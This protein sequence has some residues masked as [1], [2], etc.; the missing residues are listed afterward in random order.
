MLNLFLAVDGE[1]DDTDDLASPASSTGSTPQKPSESKTGKVE[2]DLDDAPFLEIEE[3]E[4]ASASEH[5]ASTEKVTE[6]EV[7]SPAKNKKKKK[8]LAVALLAVLVLGGGAGAFFLFFGGEPEVA[9]APEEGG[10]EVVIVQRWEDNVVEAQAPTDVVRFAPFW[11]E[12]KDPEGELHILNLDFVA[13]AASTQTLSELAVKLPSL[14]DDLFFAF[15]SKPYS[16][17]ASTN[18]QDNVKQLIIGT[19][20]D[21]LGSSRDAETGVT[22]QREIVDV[23]L[24]EFVFK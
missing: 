16:F 20:N 5:R 23:M 7:T 12:L 3:P 10:P 21:R 2:L 4:P 1:Q 13:V 18:G 14:R 19:V 9:L 6:A 22:T 11:I 24:Q 15:S 17:Y 8:I